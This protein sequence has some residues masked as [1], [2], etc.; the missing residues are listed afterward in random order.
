M[1][2]TTISVISFNFN[3]IFSVNPEAL[4]Q[5]LDKDINIERLYFKTILIQRELLLKTIDDLQNKNWKITKLLE[6]QNQQI[7]KLNESNDTLFKENYDLLKYRYLY[8]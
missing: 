3:F 7:A 1:S 6:L 5:F 4:R 2:K 8:R